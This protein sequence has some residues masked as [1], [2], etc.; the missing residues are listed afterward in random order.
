MGSN[1]VQAFAGAFRSRI[2]DDITL[3]PRNPRYSQQQ[4]L[5]RFRIE[6]VEYARKSEIAAA[7]KARARASRIWDW[8]EELV[9]VS[10]SSAVYYC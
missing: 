3:S 5:R 1:I 8:G 6:G 2:T 7:R 10:D 4:A 9:K